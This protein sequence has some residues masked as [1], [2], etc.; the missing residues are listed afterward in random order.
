M[1]AFS[2]GTSPPELL[3]F[4]YAL[5]SFLPYLHGETQKVRDLLKGTEKVKSRKG[6]RKEGTEPK[7]WKETGRSGG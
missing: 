7:L 1:T 6:S 2:P 3:Q 5:V 4:S